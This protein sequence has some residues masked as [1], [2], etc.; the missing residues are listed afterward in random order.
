MVKREAVVDTTAKNCTKC[1][2][3]NKQDYKFCTK[4]GNRF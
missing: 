3:E 1:G 2:K 4:C